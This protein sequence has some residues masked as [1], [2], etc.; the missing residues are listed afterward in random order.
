[1]KN[2]FP[3]FVV[4]VLI[5]GVMGCKKDS[6]LKTEYVEG[7]VTLGGTAVDNALVTYSPVDSANGVSATGYSDGTGKYT[8]TAVGGGPQKG[9]PEGEYN[10][11]VSKMNIETVTKPPLYPGEEPREETVQT[12]ILP[13][14]YMKADTTPLKKSVSKGK[15]TIDLELEK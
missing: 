15:N 9:V 1:M 3:F 6:L 4:L 11:T 5:F 7:V 14:I 8:L 12:P 2:L 13:S 10:V